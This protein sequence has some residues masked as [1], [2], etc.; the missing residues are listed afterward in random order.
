MTSSV[1]SKEVTCIYK[2][3]GAFYGKEIS[4]YESAVEFCL[5][6]NEPL[7]CSCNCECAQSE[8]IFVSSD[9]Q[10]GCLQYKFAAGF[11]S[12]YLTKILPEFQ[13]LSTRA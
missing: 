13:S 9:L 6:Y 10:L 2:E 12:L 4:T 1:L 7:S 3:L 11:I 5:I 8:F